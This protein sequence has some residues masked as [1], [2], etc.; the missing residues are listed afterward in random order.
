[1]A[2]SATKPK[3]YK[4]G[5]YTDPVYKKLARINGEINKLNKKDLQDRLGVLGIDSR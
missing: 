5:E 1:M 3:V 2:A 4:E